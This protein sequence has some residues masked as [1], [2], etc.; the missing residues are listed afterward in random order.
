MTKD[1]LHT[2]QIKALVCDAYRAA[3]DDTTRMAPRLYSAE[4]LARV[5]KIIAERSYGVGN[6]LRY[7]DIRPGEEI[8]DIGCGAGIDT[9]LAAQ[10]VGPAGSVIGLDILPEMLAIADSGIREAGLGNVTTLEGAMEAIPLPEDSVDL[11]VSNGVVNL[12]PR[13]ARALA[14]FARVLRPGGRVCLADLVVEGQQ[15]P[16]EVLVHPAAWAGCVAGV[17]TVDAFTEKLLRFGFEEV[18]IVYRRAFGIDDCLTYPLFTDDLIALMKKFIPGE[19]LNEIVTQIVITGRLGSSDSRPASAPSDHVP[20]A[21]HLFDAGDLG[22]ASG[23]PR[24]FR[25][26]I[27]EIPEGERLTTVAR[28]PSAK[29]DLPSLAR[30]LGHTVE[31]VSADESGR[32]LI[33]V[34][35]GPNPRMADVQ[36]T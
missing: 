6:P 1:L 7:A 14:E 27:N 36:I 5:P 19:R 18:Q 15:L 32:V 17:L 24:E 21:A 3:L 29:E 26:R 20:V 12:S 2:D 25:R 35:R 28:D 9:I 30:L 10:E 23:L 22:C 13:K 34:M 11:I 16:P 8:L 4:E 31:N 33:T